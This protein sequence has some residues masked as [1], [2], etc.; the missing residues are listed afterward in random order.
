MTT[1][2]QCEGPSGLDRADGFHQRRAHNDVDVRAWELR[3]D[4]KHYRARATGVLEHP[5]V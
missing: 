2:I 5:L 4:A 3:I 1:V